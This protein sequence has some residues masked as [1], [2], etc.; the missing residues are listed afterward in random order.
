M[1]SRLLQSFISLYFAWCLRLG[2]YG[3]YRK[4]PSTQALYPNLLLASRGCQV[5]EKKILANGASNNFGHGCDLPGVTGS[6]SMFSASQKERGQQESMILLPSS[7]EIPAVKCPCQYD[8]IFVF[9][10]HVWPH[11]PSDLP[12]EG[13][14]TYFSQTHLPDFCNPDLSCLSVCLSVCL[15]PLPQLWWSP[16]ITATLSGKTENDKQ[17]TLCQKKKKKKKW[18]DQKLTKLNQT[19]STY[20]I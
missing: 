3:M 7:W 11:C 10:I 19:S 2:C 1:W 15:T 8:F 5:V 18:L 9:T 12:N 14:K 6:A 17:Q 16:G 4:I 13:R 20:H